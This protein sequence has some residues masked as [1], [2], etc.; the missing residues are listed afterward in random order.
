MR[1]DKK[2]LPAI[3]GAV[4]IIVFLAGMVWVMR[5]QVMPLPGADEV[6]MIDMEQF[7]EGSSLGPVVLNDK[8]RIGA[9]LSALSSAKKTLKIS[10]NDIPVSDNFLR[11]GIHLKGER[12]TVCL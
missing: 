6:V 11:V 3:A 7:N 10:V 8:K 5:P 1:N 12:R 9:V 2:K 4:F